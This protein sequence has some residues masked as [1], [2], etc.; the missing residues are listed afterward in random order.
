[1]EDS[2]EEIV[3]DSLELLMEGEEGEI[4]EDSFDNILEQEQEQD[5]NEEGENLPNILSFNK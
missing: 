1:V 5:D 3:E 2:F 4:V